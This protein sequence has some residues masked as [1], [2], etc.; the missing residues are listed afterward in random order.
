VRDYDEYATEFFQRHPKKVNPNAPS[1]L[2]GRAKIFKKRSCEGKKRFSTEEEAKSFRIGFRHLN[3]VDR[4]QRI[5]P[6]EFCNGFHLATNRSS[7]QP[8][9][10]SMSAVLVNA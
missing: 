7:V 9:L 1:E 6:C 4:D 2:H 3:L 8:V 5:Y 10:K